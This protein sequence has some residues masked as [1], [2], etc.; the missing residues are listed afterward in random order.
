MS[1]TSRQVGDKTA[2]MTKVVLACSPH[3]SLGDFVVVVAVAAATVTGSD[4]SIAR[5][6]INTAGQKVQLAFLESMQST[7]PGDSEV[8]RER[9]REC[10]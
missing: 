7:S 2:D 1:L 9:E 10:G 6:I 4:E 5:A 8:E 3:N